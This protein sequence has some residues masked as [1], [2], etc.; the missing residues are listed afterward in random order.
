M[1]EIKD[2]KPRLYQENIVHT[3][4]T[5]NTLVVLPTGMGKTA[6]AMMLAVNRLNNFNN[7]KI[8]VLAP[9]KPLVAQHM[10]TFKKHIDAKMNIFTGEVQPKLRKELYNENEIIFSTPQ[11]VANDIIGKRI[12]MKDFSLLVLDEVHK[13]VGSYDY[14]FIAKEFQR[15]SKYPRILGLTASPGS[16]KAKIDEIRKNAFVEEIEI[17]SNEDPDVKPYVQEVKIDW[18]K[19]DLPLKFI[20]VKQFLEDALKERINRL[21]GWGLVGGS[22]DLVGKGQ[23]LDLQARL[24]GNI[25]RGQKDLRLWDGIS[26]TAQCVKIN[27]AI[28]LLESQGVS[29]V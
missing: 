25:A 18:V 14:V 3:S 4:L 7:S 16:D 11:T 13:A 19:I 6:I 17:R 27:H 20:E 12:D 15:R 1:F 9:S 23:L 5:K 10:K 2:F 29:S 26:L 24:H 28:E 22:Q 21:K 8:L